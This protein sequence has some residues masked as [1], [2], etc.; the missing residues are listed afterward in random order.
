MQILADGSKS[1]RISLQGHGILKLPSRKSGTGMSSST[2]Y[3]STTILH[4][5]RVVT[6]PQTCLQKARGIPWLTFVIRLRICVS[7]HLNRL[8]ARHAHD[9]PGTEIRTEHVEHT[10]TRAIKQHR[11]VLPA[12]CL[13]LPLRF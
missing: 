9:G 10:S 8:V 12:V 5:Q 7:A 4:W 11:S 1:F 13:V 6:F 2:E 3:D